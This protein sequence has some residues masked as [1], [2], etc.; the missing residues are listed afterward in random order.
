MQSNFMEVRKNA[1]FV[2]P[3]YPFKNIE[4]WFVF[5]ANANN[6]SQ[7]MYLNFI[8]E[9][10]DSS[11][12]SNRSSVFSIAEFAAKRFAMPLKQAIIFNATF[13]IRLT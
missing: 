12:I 2:P 1:P 9:N 8:V 3:V 11:T 7:E 6:T 4:Q 5:T 13:A 10:A